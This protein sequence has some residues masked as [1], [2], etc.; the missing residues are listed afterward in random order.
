MYDTVKSKPVTINREEK[1]L[2][3]IS[4]VAQSTFAKPPLLKDIDTDIDAGQSK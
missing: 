2:K 3:L 4:Y 1:L